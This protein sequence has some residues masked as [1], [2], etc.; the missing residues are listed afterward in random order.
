MAVF[1][2][3]GFTGTTYPLHNGRLCWDATVGTITA[4][5]SAAGFPAVNAS[6]VRTDSAWRPTAIPATWTNTFT[7][8]TD[9]SFVGIAKH[10]LGSRN[11][12]IAVEYNVGGV[13][14]AFPGLGAVQPADDN[15]LLFLTAP[16]AC[17]GVRVRITAA[18][19]EPTIAVIRAGRAQEMPR[20]F[21]WTGQPITEGDRIEFEKTISLT[22]NWLGRSVV[23]DGLRFELVMDH[24]T[25]NW[26]Q[27]EFAAFKSYA[28]GGEGA[29]F[30][31]TRP[32]GYPKEVAYAWPSGNVKASREMPNK[33]VSTSVTI[34][35]EGLRPVNG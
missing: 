21:T 1:I 22:G 25:E 17:A 10:D 19:D 2:A 31:A 23:S 14:A 29:F 15:A 4:T 6:T 33:S 32:F 11:A 16:T 24:A 13:W 34:S 3:T 18:D 5:T 27:T 26:R 9:I 35:C 20:P 7:G 12:T 8:A 28:N 30:V